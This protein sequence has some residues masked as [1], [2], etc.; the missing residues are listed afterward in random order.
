MRLMS[1]KYPNKYKMRAGQHI[2]QELIIQNDGTVPWPDDT[3]LVFS[4]SQN[5]LKVVEELRLGRIM[6]QS[7]TEIRIPIKMPHWFPE[8]QDRFI[9]EYEMRYSYQTIAIGAPFKLV[10]ITVANEMGW[11]ANTPCSREEM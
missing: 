2:E 3:Y 8:D 1:I 6:P 9:L 4:G 7:C 5:Q 11:D 10:I